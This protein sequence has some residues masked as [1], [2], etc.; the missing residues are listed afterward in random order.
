MNKSAQKFSVPLNRSFLTCVLI[1]LVI[2]VFQNCATVRNAE[3]RRTAADKYNFS[4]KN[5]LSI[6]MLH[7]DEGSVFCIP[8]QYMGDYHIGKFDYNSGY[9]QIGDYEILLKRDEINISVFLN[10][11]AADDGNSDS[12]FNL[13]YLE[14]K[15]K[16]TLSKMSEPLTVKPKEDDGKYNHYYIFIEKFL[17]NDEVKKINSEYEKGNVYSRLSIE[18]DLIIDNEPQDG[19]G[20]MDDFEL[21]DG[22]A[23]DSAWFPPNLNF[24]KARYL[25]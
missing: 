24:F 4:L 1:L 12:G 5:T 7:S 21:Y 14:E 20:M 17:K 25:R 9:V 19:N 18:Y 22:I 15:G 8:V 3:T 16:I 13:V 23:A 11:A 6:F 10:E 2:F